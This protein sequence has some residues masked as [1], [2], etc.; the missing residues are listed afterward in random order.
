MA[1][2]NFV[3]YWQ[4]N[5]GDNY[6]YGSKISY[7]NTDQVVFENNL[8]ASGT[9]IHTW[10]AA[11]NYQSE[12]GIVPLPELTP[13]VTY[14]L[15]Y[16]AQIFPEKHLYIECRFFD[17]FNRQIERIFI[18]HSGQ[19]FVYPK[20]A[21]EYEISLLNTGLT[22]MTFHYLQIQSVDNTLPQ[23]Y[24]QDGLVI[25]DVMYATDNAT[26][27]KIIFNEPLLGKCSW[28]DESLTQQIRDVIQISSQ[29]TCAQFYLSDGYQNAINDTIYQLQKAYD[30]QSIQ[31]IGYGPISSLAAQFYASEFSVDEAYVTS[32]FGHIPSALQLG[33]TPGLETFSL[34][35]GIDMPHQTYLT[36]D[37]PAALPAIDAIGLFDYAERLQVFIDW[38]KTERVAHVESQ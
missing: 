2:Q 22:N 23:L 4:H 25:S 28:V 16:D 15:T 31:F 3:I 30:I 26:N 38:A 36:I 24:D 21:Y 37:R 1:E 14:Q 8:M 29:Y 19:S 6:L 17:R 20:T 32:D 12:H 7:V 9:K 34:Y 5:I 35:Q 18:K 27:L 33:K 11:G 13:G 10:H